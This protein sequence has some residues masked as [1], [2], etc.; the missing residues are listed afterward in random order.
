M[1]CGK[2]QGQGRFA[3]AIVL[4]LADCSLLLHDP[5]FLILIPRSPQTTQPS[6][7]AVLWDPL[8]TRLS[9]VAIAPRSPL[10]ARRVVVVEYSWNGN[11]NNYRS[12]SVRV[13]QCHGVVLVG[14][15][16]LGTAHHTQQCA[17]SLPTTPSPLPCPFPAWHGVPYAPPLPLPLP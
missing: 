13:R 9:L 10:A 11:Y 7:A 12:V 4:E 3:V 16:G 17:L 5:G 8:G 2:V 1:I 6:L 14:G 15:G